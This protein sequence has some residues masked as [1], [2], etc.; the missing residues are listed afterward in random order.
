[1]ILG[2]GLDVVNIERFVTR[3][4]PALTARLFFGDEKERNPRT[5]AG[6]FAVKEAVIK[7]LGGVEG[8]SWHDIHV[9]SQPTGAPHATLG[10]AT[11]AIATARGVDTVFVSISH[12]DPVAVA[13]V[14][15]EG[16]LK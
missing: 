6:M 5:L 13:M 2:I 12:D 9:T 8:F 16:N 7:A 1:M 11:Q 15:L 3:L 10:G 4:T 14:V